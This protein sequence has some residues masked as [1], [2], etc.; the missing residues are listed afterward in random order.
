MA[1]DQ[2]GIGIANGATSP[3]LITWT[4]GRIITG[5]VIRSSIHL[6]KKIDYATEFM[7]L[8]ITVRAEP[9]YTTFLNGAVDNEF[10]PHENVYAVSGAPIGFH[11]TAARQNRWSEYATAGAGFLWST[12]KLPFPEL[13]PEAKF[14][15][16]FYGG[17]GIRR[18]LSNGSEFFLE[19][20][21]WHASD[22]GR[23][24]ENFGMDSN[25]ITAGFNFH[26][27]RVHLKESLHLLIGR[28]A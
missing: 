4:D 1:Q 3:H 26:A 15:F 19:Y 25:L 6:S 24:I 11:Y 5:P 10:Q 17:A 13:S 21:W 7:P 18:R 28:S 8:I 9:F 2:W 20:R 22:A 14:N 16:T 23:T 12:K 27:H